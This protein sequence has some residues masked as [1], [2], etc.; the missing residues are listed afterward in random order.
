MLILKLMQFCRIGNIH[1]A[2]INYRGIKSIAAMH[3]RSPHNSQQQYKATKLPSILGYLLL[4]R[5]SEFSTGTGVQ[6][7]TNSLRKTLATVHYLQQ[8]SDGNN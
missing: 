7:H 3:Y 1:S 5:Q 4:A 2:N 8:T 6:R